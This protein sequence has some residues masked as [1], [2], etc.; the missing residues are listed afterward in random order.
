[1]SS[2]DA[3]KNLHEEK[4]TFLARVVVGTTVC[5][6]LILTL[7]SR[8]VHLQVLQ[9]D[10][11]SVRSDENRMRLQVIPPVRGLIY[12]RHGTLLAQNAPSFVLEI[13]PEKVPDLEDTLRRLTPLIHLTEK[14]FTRFRERLR[15]TPKYRGV[16]LKPNLSPE[17]VANYQINRYDFPG[18]D[19]R[20]ELTRHYLLGASASHVI[21][22]IGGIT[23]DDLAQVDEKAYR[24]TNYIGKTGVEK[25]H[26]DELHGMLGTMIVETNAAGRPL[27]ELDYRRGAPGRDVYLTLDADLQLTAEQALGERNGAVVAI[28]PKTGEILALVSKPGFDPHLFVE[29][30]DSITYKALNDDS[31]RPLFNRALQGQYSPGSTIKPFMALAGLDSGAISAEHGELCTGEFTLPGSDR[32]Y[33]CWQRKGHGWMNLDRAVAQSCDVYFYQTA[34]SLGIDRIHGFLSQF[35]LGRST[36]LDLP[37]EKAG[38]LPSREWKRRVRRENWYPGETLNI[39]IGQGYFLTTPLQLAQMTARMAMRG[40]GFRPHIIH[41][42]GDPENNVVTAVPP[43]PLPAIGL[44]DPQLWQRAIDAMEQVT[45]SPGG[46]AFRIGR[47]AAYRMAGKTGTV[48]VAGLSQDEAVAPKQED[49]PEHLRDHAL[50]IAFAPTDDPQIAVA[51]LAE[52][53]GSGSAAAAPIARK[54]MDAFLVPPPSPPAEV[55]AQ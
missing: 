8:L 3:I 4:Q 42:V 26:E 7:A 21:G 40:Q 20:P 23:E 43:E 22:Y 18:V 28:A 11:F 25:S 31:T 38:L 16:P 44:H 6:L 39:G 9:H 47:D 41:A 19:I 29:G 17:E 14:D 45:H 30:I 46:T 13:V 10:Y 15:K 12:D 55:V 52:H 33:R 36:G 2:Y 48:Q 37:G 50:F 34:L 1:M 51:V 53:S 35:G 5:M 32:K 49:L 24:G 27:R 54:V